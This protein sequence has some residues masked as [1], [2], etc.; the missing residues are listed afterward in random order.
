MSEQCNIEAGSGRLSLSRQESCHMSRRDASRDF[1]K[2]VGPASGGSA[3]QRADLD[4]ELVDELKIDKDCFIHKEWLRHYI[5]LI[6]STCR[7]FGVRVLSIKRCFSESKGEHY[8]IRIRPA[9]DANL[10][11]M[12]QWLL[13]DDCQRVAFNRARIKSG[14]SGWNKLFEVVGRRLRT[15]Y[16]IRNVQRKG[17]YRRQQKRPR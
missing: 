8:Y 9:I 17:L 10:A 13:G 2:R 3:M 12:L 15:I 6:R 16:G 7:R 4:V 11:N 1:S 5:R 14:L